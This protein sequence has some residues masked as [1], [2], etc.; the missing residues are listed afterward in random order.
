MTWE[1][2]DVVRVPVGSMFRR[3]GGW[4]VFV[5]EDDRAVRRAI[6]VGH[7]N[8]QVAEVLGGLDGGETVILH[9]SDRIAEGIRVVARKAGAL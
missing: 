4:A 9:P 3:D 7:M 8:S 5:V 6:D 2:E 1:S